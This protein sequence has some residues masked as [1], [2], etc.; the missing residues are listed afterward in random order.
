MPAMAG[1]VMRDSTRAL[2]ANCS[3]LE[4]MSV[5]RQRVTPVLRIRC[6]A[7]PTRSAVRSAAL[8]SMPPKPF[9]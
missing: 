1:Q 9:T 5:G 3:K 2:A 7:S 8:K 4:V 6:S